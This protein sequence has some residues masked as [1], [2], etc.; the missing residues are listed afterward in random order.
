MQFYIVLMHEKMDF[1]VKMVLKIRESS[2][3][4]MFMR[5]EIV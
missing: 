1:A 5:A 4:E 3:H 2:F